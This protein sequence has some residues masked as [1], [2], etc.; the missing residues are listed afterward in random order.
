MSK[1]YC[2]VLKFIQNGKYPILNS[3]I[4]VL[5]I[6]DLLFAPSRKYGLS[7]IVPEKGALAELKLRLDAVIKDMEDSGGDQTL[8]DACYHLLKC[9]ILTYDLRRPGAKTEK[10]MDKNKKIL[11]IKTYGSKEISFENGAKIKLVSKSRNSSV[12]EMVSGSLFDESVKGGSEGMNP[13]KL[14]TTELERRLMTDKDNRKSYLETLV[15]LLLHIRYKS[16]DVYNECV[17]RLSWD[18]VV[19][20]YVLIRPWGHEG[21]IKDEHVAAWNGRKIPV[22]Y[23]KYYKKMLKKGSGVAGGDEL[24]DFYASTMQA[25]ADSI[26]A[27]YGDDWEKL[28]VDEYRFQMTNLLAQVWESSDFRPVLRDLFYHMK[29]VCPGMDFKKESIFNVGTKDSITKASKL[30]VMREFNVSAFK[31]YVP[32]VEPEDPVDDRDDSPV[33]GSDKPIKAV[34]DSV[35]DKYSGKDGLDDMI[36]SLTAAKEMMA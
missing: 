27:S 16:P 28:W 10:I 35:Y 13:R 31:N 26:K 2:S 20:Y 18:P 29:L 15:S 11:N 3:A 7:F 36:A 9:Y 22:D 19:S 6:S 34:F 32:Q 5:C 25:M 21:L 14:M 12:W 33:I 24:D 30:M 23:A 4:D 8:D 1:P 17:K